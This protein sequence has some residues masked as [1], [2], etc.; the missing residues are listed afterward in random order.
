MAIGVSKLGLFGAGLATTIVNVGTFV[1]G[2]G[3]VMWRRPFR[4]YHIL[5]RLWRIDWP[6][7]RELVAARRADLAVDAD[8]IRPVLVGAL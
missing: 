4:K 7:L 2:L 3:F 1:A 8:G 5:A 6:L